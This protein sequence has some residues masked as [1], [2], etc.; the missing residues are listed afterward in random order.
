MSI[1]SA[2]VVVVRRT[3]ETW[4]F[5]ML[6]AYRN[7]DFPKGLVEPGEEPLQAAR[8]EVQEETL[9]ADLQFA[10][11]EVYRETAPYGPK[12][13]ARYYLA[14]TR[15]EAVT[16]PVRIELGRPE[17]NEYRWLGFEQARSLCSPRL[18]P[19]IGWAGEVIGA[20]PAA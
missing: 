16:L 17:H 12:K 20:K 5:L 18:A 10:W 6:R 3:P 2:G 9:I 19:I 7:W 13:I 14:C 4:L 1:L 11:G 15:T 8:R